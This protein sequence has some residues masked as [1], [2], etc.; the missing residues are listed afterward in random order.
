MFL[1]DVP[2]VVSRWL[3]MKRAMNERS[4]SGAVQSHTE[5]IKP[6]GTNLSIASVQRS[7]CEST[8]AK[9]AT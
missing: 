7:S 8:S 3:S 4:G 6:V 9:N 5:Q 2:R 1:A